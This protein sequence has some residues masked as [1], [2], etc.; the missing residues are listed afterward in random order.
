MHNQRTGRVSLTIVKA[1]DVFMGN[2]I[3]T[4]KNLLHCAG[5]VPLFS[6]PKGVN[7]HIYTQTRSHDNIA[8]W[9]GHV[10]G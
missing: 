7:Q 3:F 1:H 8:V 4:P 5:F 6:D 9:G 2:E 10:R